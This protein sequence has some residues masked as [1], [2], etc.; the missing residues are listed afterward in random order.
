MISVTGLQDAGRAVAMQKLKFLGMVDRFWTE[1]GLYAYVPAPYH[2]TLIMMS[3][4]IPIA[5]LFSCVCCSVS[6][7]EM[8][9]VREA[10]A[11]R[12]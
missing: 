8:E 4:G 5:M 1:N 10:E 2:Y 9:K 3:I 11:K 12:E 7:E 6:D